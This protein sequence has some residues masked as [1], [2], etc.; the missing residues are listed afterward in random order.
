M[1][2]PFKLN[3]RHWTHNTV[4]LHMVKPCDLLNVD[5]IAANLSP[6]GAVTQTT[7]TVQTQVVLSQACF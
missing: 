3:T 4:K 7:G 1:Q 5:A 6:L 2:L